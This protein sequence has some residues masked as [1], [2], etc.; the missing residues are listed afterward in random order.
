M[1]SF[2]LK[3]FSKQ[4]GP[5]YYQFPPNGIGSASPYQV[6]KDKAQEDK[7]SMEKMQAEIE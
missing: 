4:G 5:V 7:K 1:D 3:G 2:N 6:Y